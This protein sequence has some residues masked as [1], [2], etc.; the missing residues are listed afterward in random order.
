[1]A[2]AAEALS[3]I[4]FSKKALETAEM[5]KLRR[6]TRSRSNDRVRNEHFRQLCNNRPINKWILER[7]MEWKDHIARMASKRVVKIA[8]DKAPNSN[9]NIG[10]SKKRWR[11][12]LETG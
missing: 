6:I 10:R 4:A 8:R 12:S 3:D 2:Y 1:L 11:Q 9:R 7:R 5:T